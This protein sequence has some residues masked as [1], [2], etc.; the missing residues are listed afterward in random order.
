MWIFPGKINIDEH[1]KIIEAL[2]RRMCLNRYWSHNF[3]TF[4]GRSPIYDSIIG[5]RV[6]AAIH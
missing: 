5:D 3:P 4:G 2:Q 1:M 6:S